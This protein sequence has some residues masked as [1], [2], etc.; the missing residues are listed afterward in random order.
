MLKEVNDIVYENKDSADREVEPFDELYSSTTENSAGFPTLSYRSETRT[1]DAFHS[2]RLY[3]SIGRLPQWGQSILFA[4]FV[5]VARILVWLGPIIWV[6]WD[7][8]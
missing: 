5:W 4:L 1:G 8:L 6:H 2:K 7:Q 3:L